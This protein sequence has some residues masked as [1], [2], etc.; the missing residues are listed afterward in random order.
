MINKVLERNFYAHLNVIERLFCPSNKNLIQRV[1]ELSN[2][3]LRGLIGG[4]YYLGVGRDLIFIG[5]NYWA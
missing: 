3:Y 1:W 5:S 4:D 2:F